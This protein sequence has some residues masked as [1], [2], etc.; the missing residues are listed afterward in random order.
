VIGFIIRRVIGTIP[1]LFIASLLIYAILLAAPGGPEAR[2][3]QNPRMTTGQIAAIRAKWGLDQPV[4]IQYCRWL[5]ACSEHVGFKDLQADPGNLLRLFVSAQGGPNILPTGLGGGDNGVLHGDL[6]FS[7]ATGQPVASVIGQRVVPTA[8]LGGISLIVWVTLA[9][10]SGV[11]AAAR[12]YGKLDTAITIFNYVGF[13]FPTFWLGILL[14]IVFAGILKILPAGGMWD[15]RTVPIFGTSE[16]WAFFGANTAKALLD[17]AQH[18][19]L[20]VITLVFVSIAADSRFVRAAM[21]DALNQDYIRTARAKGVPERRVITRHALRNALLPVVTNISLELPLLFTGAVATETI[22]S[23]PGMGRAYI[24]A[25]A[26]FDYTV[27]MGIL[28]IT[29]VFVVAANLLADI[30]YAIVD[31]RISYG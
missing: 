26:Q 22:F 19:V 8:I 16:Y 1:T 25:V 14:V 31:P 13:S 10:I 17:L 5:G 3:A 4:P 29:A 15:A 27:L 21:I 18:L 24:E 30:V 2:F 6:G 11:I 12:R 20:P 9:V 23:W 28:S 7:S